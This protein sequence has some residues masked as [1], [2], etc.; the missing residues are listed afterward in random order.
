[1]IIEKK[2]FIVWFKFTETERAGTK[3]VNDYSSDDKPVG[4][5]SASRLGG[6]DDLHHLA[7]LQAKIPR[8]GI[9]TLDSHQLVVL[10]LVP[11]QQLLL[12][13]LGHHNMLRH[14]LM[15][16]D[17]DQQLGLEELLEDVLGRHVHQRLLG[18]GG[19]PHLHHNHC[20]GDVLL[21]HSCAICFDGLDPNFGII[22]E[23]DKH[24]VCGVVIV[25]YQNHQVTPEYVKLIL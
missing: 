19:H 11:Q 8:H 24:L 5:V 10:Q 23:E 9:A 17:V 15:L 6:A 13:L 2:M 1:M 12:L 7:S 25:R 16:G 20:S 18:A 3:T 14:K 22:R 21:L 4:N